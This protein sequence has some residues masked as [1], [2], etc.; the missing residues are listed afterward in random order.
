MLNIIMTPPFK[1]KITDRQAAFTLIELLVVIAIIGILA[2]TVLASLSDARAAARDTER[3][4]DMRQ[5]RTALELFYLQ[6]QRYPNTS[7]DGIDPLGEFIGVGAPIDDVLRPFIDQVPA[8]PLHDGTV[9]FYSYDPTHYIDLDCTLPGEASGV[10]FGF[11]RAEG[12]TNLSKDTCLGSNMNL[13]NAD[14]NVG[15]IRPNN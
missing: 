11:N 1:Q 15:F 7:I 8:D 2:T 10:V 4:S 6:N 13:H 9:Y 3:L 12:L 5:I 14:Y